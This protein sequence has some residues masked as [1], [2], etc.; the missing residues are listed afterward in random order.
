MTLKKLVSA[1]LN[2]DFADFEDCVQ[3]ECA[4]AIN[5]DYIITGNVKDFQSSKVK[6]VTPEEFLKIFER[7]FKN[8]KPNLEADKMTDKEIFS[9]DD[10]NYLPVFNRYKI[11]L[12]RGEG[13]YLYDLSGKNV[14][15]FTTHEGSGLGASVRDIKKTCPNVTV[16][17]GMAIHGADVKDAKRA[18]QNWLK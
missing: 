2:F 5:A 15:V 18:I 11:V 9:R 17:Q 14:M 6:A 16:G 1:V 12:E 13:A 10:N 4:A 3:D 7:Q 8:D